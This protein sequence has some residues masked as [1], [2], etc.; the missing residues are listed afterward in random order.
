MKKAFEMVLEKHSKVVIIGSDCPELTAT[1][2][3]DAFHALNTHDVVVGP[4]HDGGYYLLGLTEFYSHLFD[5]I[6]WSTSSVFHQ[7]I[8]KMKTNEISF[9]LLPT[10][11]DL[12]TI[13]D[14][15]KFPRFKS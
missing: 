1:I 2:I 14:L 10:L 9:D 15:E 6:N 4:S 7:T 8:E 12:D 11:Y 3:E 13:D 5:N